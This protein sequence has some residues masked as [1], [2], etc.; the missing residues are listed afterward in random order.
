MPESKRA[1]SEEDA[2]DQLAAILARA[3]QATEQLNA[4]VAEDKVLDAR[5]R[6]E[7]LLHDGN[8]VMERMNRANLNQIFVRDVGNFAVVGEECEQPGH[9]R[10]MRRRIFGGVVPERANI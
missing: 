6:K 8:F 7:W 9:L 3:K 1:A 5:E 4:V 2:T 10:G